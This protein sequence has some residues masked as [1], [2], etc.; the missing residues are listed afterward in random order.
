MIC[1]LLK[2]W[3]KILS[4]IFVSMLLSNCAI[5]SP[6]ASQYA[7][8]RAASAKQGQNPPQIDPDIEDFS[9]TPGEDD[10]D[11]AIEEPDDET[12]ND[13]EVNAGEEPPAVDPA[14][15]QAQLVQAGTQVYN[16]SCVNCHGPLAMSQKLNRTAAQILAAQALPQHV[17]VQW[18][19]QNDAQAL[20]AALRSP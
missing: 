9:E 12:A 2:N 13:D 20:E 10:V 16:Q 5:D 15:L 7:K 14:Q 11:V 6:V 17:Q 19:N 18:P 8:D 1:A 4:L 3:H